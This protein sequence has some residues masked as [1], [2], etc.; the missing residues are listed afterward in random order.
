MLFDRAELL[1]RDHKGLILPRSGGVGEILRFDYGEGGGFRRNA[2]TI[3]AIGARQ[4]VTLIAK[5][6]SDNEG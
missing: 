2:R 4:G 6:N 1:S 5:A 3:N